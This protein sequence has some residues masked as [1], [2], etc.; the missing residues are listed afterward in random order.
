[1][2][3]KK[4]SNVIWSDEQWLA[5]HLRGYNILVSAGAGSGK[6]AVLSQR[7]LEYV[8][9]GNSISKLIV[10]TFTNASASEMKERIRSCLLK[11]RDKVD[12]VEFDLLEGAHIETFDAFSLSL[13]K[14]YHYLL[15]VSKQ[16]KFGN[17]VVLENQKNLILQEMFDEY[18]EEEVFRNFLNIYSVNNASS[19]KDYFLK[20]YNA[21]TIV[22]GFF[23]SNF[24]YYSLDFI[25]KNLVKYHQI[26][27][28]DIDKLK[29]L[30]DRLIG[31]FEYTDLNQHVIDCAQIY[32]ELCDCKT[33]EEIN[34]LT[35][36]SMPTT[37]RKLDSED[38]R[39]LC[40]A[41]KK[42][43][44]DLVK[45]ILDN[46]SISLGFL[47]NQVYRSKEYADLIVSFVKDFT[48][49]I[50]EYKRINNAYEFMDVALLAIR[51]FKENPE[52]KAY[53][54]SYYNEIL[55]DEYQ[56]T[57]D[58]QEE[59]INLI[60]NNNVYM[61][62]DMKQSIYRFRNANPDIFKQKY[63]DYDLYN[64]ISEKTKGVKI[65][66][67]NNFR[68]RKEV[69]SNINIIFE[70]LMDIDLGGVKYEDNQKLS[71][72]NKA[73]L[74]FEHHDYNMEFIEYESAGNKAYKEAYIIGKD[75]LSKLENKYMC[76]DKG[77]KKGYLASY[78]DFTILTLT[79]SN[80]DI[81]QRVFEYLGIPLVAH[82]D[83]EF[84]D[85]KEI[86]VLSNIIKC[87]YSMLDSDYYID[88]FKPALISVLR[89]FL[90]DVC[91]DKI[92]LSIKE[93]TFK[94][95][96]KE[97][98]L[99]LND[100]VA[101]AKKESLSVVLLEIYKRFDFYNKA[102]L[103]GGIKRIEDKLNSL[104]AL[105]IDFENDGKTFKD[106]VDFFDLV[107]KTRLDIDYQ[108]TKS[109]VDAVN[110]MT[111]HKSK[112]LEYPICY[113]ADL[114][115]R[116]NISEYKDHI[117]FDKNLG[118]IMP[119]FE[120]KLITPI[121]KDLFVYSSLKE[122][123]SEK[124]RLLYVAL[125]RAK[126]KM[127]FVLPQF[128][129]QR[130]VLVVNSHEKIMA[131]S[132]YDM[133]TSVFSLDKKINN[134]SFVVDANIPNYEDDLKLINEKKNSIVE[135]EYGCYETLD[136]SL[137]KEKIDVFTPS[138]GVK[139]LKEDSS[140]LDFGTHVHLILETLDF[141]NPDLSGIEF[142]LKAKIAK[143]CEYVKSFNP[144]RYYQE[145][146]FS[147]LEINGIIDLIIETNDELIVVDYKL[148]DINKEEYTK[149]VKLYVEYLKGISNKK[150]RG[151]LY[152]ILDSVNEVIV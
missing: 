80:Y 103:I 4:P 36:Q 3:P 149:Q 141:D 124:I 63:E 115:K 121:Y 39:K 116:F 148:K 33:I 114:T 108:Q 50:N 88:N 51:L 139:G 5:I 65:D 32:E 134:Q 14:K 97:L 21:I 101:L 92:Y 26:A 78:S 12:P 42:E 24:D 140:A 146:A 74:E 93:N 117:F 118:I 128:E 15:G 119:A 23:D 56:D 66:L 2:I 127:I 46:A 79:K 135:V 113:F 62:G 47:Q 40:T 29:F 106:L 138:C 7:V 58:I 123:I 112:G 131:K 151:E 70:K 27:F 107:I 96:Y 64:D 31:D 25:E 61:V 152:S 6:T 137:K 110:I 77:S 100:L 136:Y 10:L 132:F 44:K 122:D 57:S 68:S 105:V 16:I 87:V 91:D 82:K 49:R 71:F 133:I 9:Q 104:L 111:I 90:V 72:G 144:I 86:Y 67:I 84:F 37:P 150:I 126:E 94:D 95:E 102:I 35:I 28:D 75:I 17:K 53:F 73:Y 125:T 60:S 69:L 83:A 55:V 41:K 98:F 8:L 85:S 48:F 52:L 145:Y 147:T 34:E 19:I 1:M 45:K 38:T 59:L 99:I 81:Y 18:L 129:P 30:K 22:P 20:I 11:N 54:K 130:D 109:N 13:V 120:S 143:L 43:I 142:N 89:S 76:F